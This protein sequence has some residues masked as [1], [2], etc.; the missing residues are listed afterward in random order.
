MSDFA[1]S[2]PQ[3]G[4][5]SNMFRLIDAARIPSPFADADTVEQSAID[6]R[7]GGE[8]I[9]TLAEDARTTWRGLRAHYTAPESDDLFAAMDPVVETAEEVESD[10]AA[11][12]GALDDFAAA[13]RTAQTTLHGLRE[14]ALALRERVDADAAMWWMKDPLALWDNL[15]IK[16]EVNA[17]WRAY[18]EAETACANSISALA[19]GPTYV[20]P[21]AYTGAADEIPYGM[22]SDA[23]AET[24]GFFDLTA[25]FAADQ[26]V[27]LREGGPPWPADWATGYLTG[28]YETVFVDIGWGTGV[29]VVSFLGIWSPSGGWTLRLDERLANTGE[30]LQGSLEGTAALVGLH[31]EDGWLLDPFGGEPYWGYDA[32][33]Q[34]DNAAAEWALMREDYFAW[35]EWGENNPHAT[36][37]VVINVGTLPVSGP[38]R[39][40]RTVLGRRGDGADGTDGGFDTDVDGGGFAGLDPAALA[41]GRFDLGDLLENLDGESPGRGFEDL[42]PALDLDLDTGD[43]PGATPTPSPGSNPSPTPNPGPDLSPRPGNGEPGPRG[44]ESAPEPERSGGS[45]GGDEPPRDR[46][47]TGGG[48][49]DDGDE[50]RDGP[51]ER[52][53]QKEEEE[54]QSPE[55]VTG[56]G[57]HG[58]DPHKPPSGDDNTDGNSDGD[59]DRD[60]DSSEGPGPGSSDPDSSDYQSP[61]P[62]TE[63]YEARI[64]ELMDDP[65]KKNDNPTQRQL[66]KARREAE[67]GLAAE[68]Q[69]L[70]PGPIQRAEIDNSDPAFQR[71]QG[72]IVD[73]GGQAWD[74]K[75][76]RDTFPSGPRAGQPMPPG[77]RGGF[78]IDRIENEI[79]GELDNGENVLLDISGISAPENLNSLR[80]VMGNNPEWLGKVIIV[81]E[82]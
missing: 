77:M 48:D 33:T 64:E 4:V 41:G 51:A 61:E 53:E 69:G 58:G 29:E 81:E 12:A 55:T 35:S 80:D 71:D 18:T 49:G 8:E 67:V 39:V 72:D 3:E 15:E 21:D 47:A 9:D 82:G 13:V 60:N 24:T 22:A 36:G 75:G 14:R 17:A 54:D 68:R 23:G 79:R 62:G 59:G 1:F 56:S 5:D 11:V 74:I 70:V 73:A 46:P 78:D 19:D 16:N 65:A 34:R 26:W 42:L 32:D 57:G 43:G 50:S 76:F 31:G 38:L 37:V 52:D 25:R 20:A 66:D 40:L 63:A 45:G 44:D 2:T 7:T 30:Y 10:L 28:V 6:L 27:W